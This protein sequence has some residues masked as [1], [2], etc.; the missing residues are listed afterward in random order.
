MVTTPEQYKKAKDTLSLFLGHTGVSESETYRVLRAVEVASVK[1][2]S[3]K[4]T[5]ITD[6]N[7]IFYRSSLQ[8]KRDAYELDLR[9]FIV[10]SMDEILATDKKKASEFNWKMF[11]Q[12]VMQTTA[13]HLELQF[14]DLW[15]KLP[16]PDQVKISNEIAVAVLSLIRKDQN[17]VRQ[18]L[19]GLSKDEQDFI[20]Q[21]FSTNF[22][23]SDPQSRIISISTPILAEIIFK[24]QMRNK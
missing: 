23:I 5:K 11:Q 4:R 3:G 13:T 6:E 14:G 8:S 10:E 20:N 22:R 21:L 7:Q 16:Y 1:D 15:T 2:L 24:K 18:I 19:E 17:V 12:M 9:E